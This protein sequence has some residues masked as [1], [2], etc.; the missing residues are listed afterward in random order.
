MAMLHREPII[1]MHMHAHKWES[2]PAGA[3]IPRFPLNPQPSERTGSATS[4]NEESLQRTIEAMDRCNIVLGFLSGDPD[5]VCEW[6][7]AV[8]EGRPRSIPSV[9]SIR[10]APGEPFCR[11]TPPRIPRWS[12]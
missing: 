6:V 4:S 8:G 5:V 3:P 1:D 2:T 12:A 11:A 9:S 10:R 7:K